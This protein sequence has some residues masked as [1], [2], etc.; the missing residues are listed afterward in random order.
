MDGRVYFVS[1]VHL[2][3]KAGDPDER[4]T[5]FVSFI[6]SIPREGTTALCMLGDIWDFWYEYRDVIP[7]A[8]ARALAALISLMDDGVEVW[9]CPGNHDVWTFSFF[10]KLGMHRIDQPA[11]VS[12]GGKEFCLGHGDALGKCDLGSR[13]VSAL[14]HCRIAQILFSTIHPWLAYRFGSA[15]SESNRKKHERRN[16][17]RG[18][19]HFKGEQEPLFRYALDV[20][21]RRHVDFFI[22]GHFHDPFRASLPDGAGFI[23]LDDWMDGG[24]PCAF[25]ENGVVSVRR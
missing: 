5:R 19:Y 20:S 1:D 15:W 23:I 18:G 3:L 8:G 24:M 17:K 13:L 11:F 14:F 22:F 7:R 10:E 9:F 16:R 25:F 21:A 6:N 12:V 4:E 2:G